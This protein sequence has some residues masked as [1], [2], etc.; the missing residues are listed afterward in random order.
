[1][2]SEALPQEQ[3][4]LWRAIEE[5]GRQ[6]AGAKSEGKGWHSRRPVAAFVVVD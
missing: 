2:A 5:G 1:M 3:M 4:L 6:V